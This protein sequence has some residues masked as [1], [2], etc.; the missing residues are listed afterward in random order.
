MESMYR[1]SNQTAPQSNSAVRRHQTAEVL[2]QGPM[3]VY[4]DD[5]SQGIMR[6]RVTR[7]RGLGAILIAAAAERDG[8]TVTWVGSDY[9]VARIDNKLVPIV[10]HSCTETAVAADIVLD[11][12]LTKD[13]LENAGVPVPQGREVVSASDAVRAQATL[14]VAV[15]VKPR[16]GLMGRGITVNISDPDDV[17]GAYARARQHGRRVLVEEYVEGQEY[18]CHA[19]PDGTVGVFRRLL[20]NVIGDGHSTVA[21][22]VE[23]K[24]RLRERNPTTRGQVIPFDEVTV[25]YLARQGITSDSIIPADEVLIV[26]DVNGITSGGDSEEYL[27]QSSA[28]LLETAAAAVAAIPGMTWAGVDILWNPH[29][30]DTRVME[31][32]TNASINGSSMPVFGTP[33]DLPALVWRRIL[34]DTPYTSCAVPMTPGS[35][36][37]PSTLQQATMW[38][39]DDAEGQHSPI[40]LDALLRQCLALFGHSM[41]RYGPRG[42]YTAEVGGRG[43]VQWCAGNLTQRDLDSARRF[44]KSRGAW[45]GA[46]ELEHVPL[47][48]AA[49]VRRPSDLEDFRNQYPDEDVVTVAPGRRGRWAAGRTVSA[50]DSVGDD[51]FEVRRTWLVQ[52]HPRGDRLRVFADNDKSSAVIRTS[53]E[54]QVTDEELRRASE[55]AVHAVRAVPGL[56]WACVE[57]VLTD[58]ASDG[59]SGRDVLVEEITYRPTMNGEDRVIAGSIVSLAGMIVDL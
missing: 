10:G 30:D 6:Q 27:D 3:N 42:I 47:V 59:E 12:Q 43:E 48:P 20:P 38:R 32:N 55:V 58:Q 13:F 39:G 36:A 44:L 26:R 11:K 17:R 50:G 25:R 2:P 9:A 35:C 24:N 4:D 28:K 7:R 33:R 1:G 5:Q 51:H 57:V 15:V 8:A 56:R 29:T 53:E 49:R 45:R 21:E 52:V 14:G 22:L 41:Q 34:E 16:F 37:V 19:S 46:L 31:V 23:A 54:S 40:P 18:R